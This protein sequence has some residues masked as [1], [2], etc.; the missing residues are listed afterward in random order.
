MSGFTKWWKNR[1][2]RE[3]SIITVAVLVAVVYG[4]NDFVFDPFYTKFQVNKDELESQQDLL[5]RYERLINS[6]GKAKDKL[7]NKLAMENSID[8]V[9]LNSSTSDL[10]NAELQGVVKTLAKKADIAFTQ[11][12]PKKTTELDGFSEI[13]LSMPFR[14]NIL[15]I[16]NFLYEL[17]TAD[18]LI[19]TDRL[20]IKRMRRK[21]QKLRVDLEITAYIRNASETE[22]SNEET[23]KTSAL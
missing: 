5:K 9:L 14:G 23:Q 12:T 22:G 16:Q 8:S 13:K 7:G 10:A 6:A 17:E 11:I 1:T 19:H 3:R 18:K 20:S 2:P 15:Q 21:Q 4:F